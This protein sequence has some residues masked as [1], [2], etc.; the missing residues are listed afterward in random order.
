MK[1]HTSNQT[2]THS[3]GA[4]HSLGTVGMRAEQ[5]PKLFSIITEK[6]YEDPRQAFV[7]ELMTNMLDAWLQQRD[8]TGEAPPP[9]RVIP[10][11]DLRSSIRFVDYGPGLTPDEVKQY[12]CHILESGKDHTNDY[13]GGWGL[14]MKSPFAYTASWSIETFYRDQQDQV[15]KM[16]LAT[17]LQHTGV[18]E[19][20]RVGEPTPCDPGTQTGLVVDVPVKPD[21][22]D[23]VLRWARWYAAYMPKDALTIF[24]SQDLPQ[25]Q[26]SDHWR[27]DF[28]FNNHRLTWALRTEHGP[29]WPKG[30]GAYGRNHNGCRIILGAVAYPCPSSVQRTLLGRA[31][32]DIW[33][34]IGSLQVTPDRDRFVE[35]DEHQQLLHQLNDTL[36]ADISRL[37]LEDTQDGLPWHNVQR[38]AHFEKDLFSSSVL[39]KLH[40]IEAHHNGQPFHYDWGRFTV[41]NATRRIHHTLSSFRIPF[42]N[43]RVKG[44][45]AQ[46]SIRGGGDRRDEVY[47]HPPDTPL[48]IR[49][50]NLHAI[51]IDDLGHGGKT[52]VMN[53]YL[54][55]RSSYSGTYSFSIF[56][57]LPGRARY[58]QTPKAARR[59]ADA[60]GVPQ[61]LVQWVSD[62]PAPDTAPLH[63]PH[64]PSNKQPYNLTARLRCHPLVSTV[65]LN[66]YSRAAFHYNAELDDLFYI[67][68]NRSTIP[69]GIIPGFP[70]DIPPDEIVDRLLP[71]LR[72]LPDSI[73]VNAPI[74]LLPK[75]L[76]R[77]VENLDNWTPLPS[78]LRD[79]LEDYC[80]EQP[81][82]K[83]SKYIGA[84]PTRYRSVVEQLYYTRFQLQ[85]LRQACNVK[86]P[87][88][89]QKALTDAHQLIEATTFANNT[90]L[91]AYLEET[92]RFHTDKVRSTLANILRT[93]RH[94][95]LLAL[96]DKHLSTHRGAPVLTLPPPTKASH[97]TYASPPS[98]AFQTLLAAAFTRRS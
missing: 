34:P 45:Q 35:S 28:T 53:A 69:A 5:A 10:P 11:S 92:G 63:S 74:V 59:L 44:L 42:K 49:P 76:A 81:V 30:I 1:V 7:R 65:R 24:T 47:Q 60:L 21:D 40:E 90:I 6:M 79:R 75:S 66:S 91:R 29:S 9:G 12:V 41:P 15:W 68:C 56:I 77:E 8:A 71:A 39:K 61:D 84:L 87:K 58:R 19:V 46:V 88:D 94:Y 32:I 3:Q 51:Y 89:L 17:Y 78:W 23:M 37:I 27:G 64:A 86:L 38:H 50:R 14:G 62:L 48:H 57:T 98:S 16:Q 20:T 52:R 55:K 31:P 2:A 33:A 67:P 4:L 95:P 13:H 85:T 83:E 18:P 43:Q 96:L 80:Q 22:H 93:V 26:W 97:A 82:P 54:P 25:P 72:R 73:N 70:S 36:S